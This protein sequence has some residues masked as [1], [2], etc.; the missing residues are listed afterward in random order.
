M[1]S[2]YLHYV[3]VIRA[4]AL[5]PQRSSESDDEP[6][7]PYE[8]AS[9]IAPA[10][11]QPAAILFDLDGTLIDTVPEI[12]DALNDALAELAED[13]LLDNALVESWVGGGAANLLKLALGHCGVPPA[14]LQREFELRWEHFQPAY[15][16]RCGTNSK[17][18][19]GVLA[20]L[21]ALQEAGYKLGVVTN[22]EGRFAEKVIRNHGIENFFGVVMAGDT[23]TIKKP[24]P[25]MLWTALGRLGA[26]N[27][28]G[29]FIG[30]SMIDVATGAAAGVNTWAVTHGYHHGEFDLP[31]T[32][33]IQPQRFIANF[34]QLTSLL[35]PNG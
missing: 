1:I 25:A 3:C 35:V 29:L 33:E 21:Q 27:T 24:D 31:F 8:T 10:A 5:P 30:D 18:Y 15:E 16:A 32:A 17:P 19:P 26:G 9:V 4:R 13:Q 22:K 7:H 23:L 6:N 34:A 12:A 20:S 11:V 14:L 2:H 28:Q